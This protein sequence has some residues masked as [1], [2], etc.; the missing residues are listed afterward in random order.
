[1]TGFFAISSIVFGN[2]GAADGTRTRTEVK[3]WQIL[4]LR[5][6][7]EKAR[8]AKKSMPKILVIARL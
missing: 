2:H 6:N 8:S 3:F 5:P 4:R 1:M 7:P